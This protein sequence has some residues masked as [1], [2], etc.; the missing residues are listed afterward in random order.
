ML[1]LYIEYFQYTYAWLKYSYDTNKYLK[2]IFTGCGKHI[3]Q[4]LKDVPEAE[5]CKCK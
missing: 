1:P 4:V 5:R 3:E 2:I